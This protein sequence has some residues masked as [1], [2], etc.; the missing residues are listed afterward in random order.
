MTE[1]W[2]DVSR[3]KSLQLRWKSR[4]AFL[5]VCFIYLFLWSTPATYACDACNIAPVELKKYF[6]TMQKLMTVLDIKPEGTGGKTNDV[7][8]ATKAGAQSI[9]MTTTIWF[10]LFSHVAFADMAWEIKT[11]AGTAA[12]RRD[13]ELFLQIDRKLMMKWIDLAKNAYVGKKLSTQQLEKID[14]YLKELKYLSLNKEKEYTMKI[15]GA[16]YDDL[17]MLYRNM[18][19]LYKTLHTKKRYTSDLQFVGSEQVLTD[20]LSSKETIVDPERQKLQRFRAN[21]EILV[22][23]IFAE[24]H[25]ELQWKTF[26]WLSFKNEYIPFAAHI[27]Q[28]EDAYACAIWVKNQ[29]DTNRKNTVAQQ[30]QNTKDRMNISVSVKNTFSEAWDR[31]RWA[32]RSTDAGLKQKANQRQEALMRSIY[33]RDLPEKRKWFAANGA[34]DEEG[35]AVGGVITYDFEMEN[36]SQDSRA[37]AKLIQ[38][39]WKN[40]RDPAMKKNS[41][42]NEADAPSLIPQAAH[43]ANPDTYA[44]QDAKEAILKTYKEETKK[45]KWND[46]AIEIQWFLQ[47]KSREN[48]IQ[49]IR[50]EFGLILKMQSERDI[51]S[52]FVDTKVA[53]KQFPVLSAVVYEGIDMRWKK[54]EPAAKDGASIYNS[55]GKVCELQCTNVQW[56][57]WYYTD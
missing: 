20:N 56:K 8:F 30:R 48:D 19:Y 51:E 44:S 42:E 2:V 23:T 27:R 17:L 7:I 11:L 41:S 47:T 46:E 43:K 12:R 13:R 55:M 49:R 10:F 45:T 40:Q 52:A 21:V 9:G 36:I 25:S 18:N 3:I 34:I 14:E 35:N 53:T 54:N 31:L 33:G 1:K 29:C 5:V 6:D 26:E 50:Q 24:T 15:H 16:T 37:L 57:C 38:E 39:A 28:I 32:L 22:K 4:I